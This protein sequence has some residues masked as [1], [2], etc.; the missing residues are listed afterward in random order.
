MSHIVERGES[1]R[2]RERERESHVTLRDCFVCV[3]CS[4]VHIVKFITILQSQRERETISKK[5]KTIDFDQKFQREREY[6]IGASKEQSMW[7]TTEE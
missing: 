7:I 1:D 4:F 6:G 5:R 3:E 2:E